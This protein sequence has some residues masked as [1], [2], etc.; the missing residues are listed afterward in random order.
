MHLSYLLY[1]D[2]GI[3]SLA[4]QI[5]IAGFAAFMMFFRNSFRRFFSFRKKT[6]EKSLPDSKA[7]KNEKISE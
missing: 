6:D 2:P 5:V 7:G 4:V 3:G 1:I